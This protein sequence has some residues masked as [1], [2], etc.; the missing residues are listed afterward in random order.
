MIRTRRAAVAATAVG[1]AAAAQLTLAPAAL[2]AERPLIEVRNTSNN[3]FVDGDTAQVTGLYRC[4]PEAEFTHTWVSVKQGADMGE[5]PSGSAA[6]AW[7]DTNVTFQGEEPTLECDGTWQQLTVEVG[8]YE[9]KQQLQRGDAY[10]QW[11][12]VA[13]AGERFEEPSLNTWV[14]VKTNGR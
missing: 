1:L 12:F 5:H 14:K 11:C 13:V 7:Y 2:A 9:H 10:L 6:T 4:S 8:R 3:V